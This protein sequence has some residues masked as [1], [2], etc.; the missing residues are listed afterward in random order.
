MKMK[1]IVLPKQIIP[2]LKNVFKKSDPQQ[3]LIEQHFLVHSKN[4]NR[5]MN[6]HQM[7]KDV[8]ESR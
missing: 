8:D 2:G 5:E 1:P 7:L 4:Q 6:P 3:S